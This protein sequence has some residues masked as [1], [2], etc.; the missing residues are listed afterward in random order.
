MAGR[1]TRANFKHRGRAQRVR[2]ATTFPMPIREIPVV[3]TEFG[4]ETMANMA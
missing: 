4:N 3:T 2:R 1:S